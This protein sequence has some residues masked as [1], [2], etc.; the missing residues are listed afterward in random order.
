MPQATYSDGKTK[1]QVNDK[2]QG[3]N[4]QGQPHAGRVVEV[5]HPG[6]RVRV[7]PTLLDVS[8]CNASDCTQIP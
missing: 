3:K 1:A 5:D 2:V 6:Q 8:W 4:A 7:A